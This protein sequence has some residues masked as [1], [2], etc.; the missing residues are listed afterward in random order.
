VTRGPQAFDLVWTFFGYADD[1]PEMHQRRLR[2][3]NLMGP[4]GY[5]SID[6][7]EVM[8]ASQAGIAPYPEAQGLF[9]MGGR[10]TSNEA[11]MVTEGAIRGFYNYYRNVMGL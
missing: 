3:A 11:H 6:D 10:G 1:T 2:Q 8:M 4:S 5:V 7:S 9:E